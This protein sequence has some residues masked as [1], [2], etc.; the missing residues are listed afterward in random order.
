MKAVL[1]TNVL[2]AGLLSPV[3]PCGDIVRM[4]SL[5]W[6]STNGHLEEHGKIT[7][8]MEVSHERTEQKSL[9]PGV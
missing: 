4:V 8:Q 3:N 2:V 5:T 9:H 7:Q 6:H 1:D